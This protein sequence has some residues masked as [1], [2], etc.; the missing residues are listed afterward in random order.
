MQN[1]KE[2]AGRYLHTQARPGMPVL[3]MASVH[4][5]QCQLMTCVKTGG[6]TV[7]VEEWQR[8]RSRKWGLRW[9]EVSRAGRLVLGLELELQRFLQ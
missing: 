4:L 8:A 3:R 2:L 5:G 6:G 1:S 7:G 9:V